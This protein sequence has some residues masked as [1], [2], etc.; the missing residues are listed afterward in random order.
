M[1]HVVIIGAGFAGLNAAKVLSRARAVSITLIDRNNHHVF[2]PLLYQVAMAELSPADI[3]E[4]IRAMFRHRPN[5]RVLQGEVLRID[6]ATQTVQTSFGDLAYDYLILATGARHH[7][8]GHEEWEP[9]APGLKTL[10]QATEIRRRVLAAFEAAESCNDADEQARLLRFVI[11]GGGPTG[12][13][14]AGA[15]GEIGRFTLKHNFRRIDPARARIILVEAGPRIL[16]T[17]PDSLSA[18][19]VRDLG[20]LGVEVRCS[21]A[22]TD[23]TDQGVRVGDDW[24]PAGTVIWAAGVQPSTLGAQLDVPQDRQGRVIVNPDL[25]I[26][27][28]ARVFVAGDLAHCLQDGQPLPGVAGVALQQG[29]YLGRLL[30]R[31]LAGKARQPFRYLDKGQMATIGHNKALA[32]IG[33]LRLAGYP[34][35]VIWAFLHIYYLASFHNRVFVFLQWAWLYFTRRRGARLIL[36]GDWRFYRKSE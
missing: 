3:A 32:V 19:A 10:G 20:K 16:S 30:R 17:F 13:E 29:R 23:I 11:V 9:L 34:A 4:P 31:E 28:D 15:I 26:P 36:G 6:R 25:S 12:V 24:L 27:G 22:V 1:S 33:R 14:L 5:V 8:F 2:Q 21:T 35:W 18:R 7:Y